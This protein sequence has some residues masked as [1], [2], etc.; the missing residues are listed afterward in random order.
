MKENVKNAVRSG[1]IEW[2][3]HAFEQMMKRA[4]SRKSVKE[5]LVSGEIIEE[6]HNKPFLCA[7][8]FL[9]VM[10]VRII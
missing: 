8:F 3:K 1:T 10:I 6:Y 5:V 9:G 2:R 4:I 7:L